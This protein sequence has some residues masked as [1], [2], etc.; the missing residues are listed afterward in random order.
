[1]WRENLYNCMC[2]FKENQHL[3]NLLIW[4]EGQHIVRRLMEH[5]RKGP[6]PGER[7]TML[8]DGLYVRRGTTFGEWACIW[9]EGQCHEMAYTQREGQHL[10]KGLTCTSEKRANMLRDGLYANI[11]TTSFWRRGLYSKKANMLWDG[12]YVR[13]GT[14]FGEWAYIWEEGQCHEMA[15]M[16]KDGQ[17]LEK[18]LAFKEGQY[19]VRW[20]LCQKGDNIWRRGLYL[21]RA[22]VVKWLICKR[23]ANIWTGG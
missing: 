3:Q 22:N 6:V 12:L 18:G 15:Y 8:W 7:A 13:R 11:G 10:E 2:F 20:L 9:E 4:W 14:T 5:L 19:V 16:Q 1:M 17:H 21:K 23:R